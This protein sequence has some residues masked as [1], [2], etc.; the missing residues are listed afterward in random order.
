MF[1]LVSM[2]CAC[3]L[4]LSI[5]LGIAGFSPEILRCG[6][7]VNCQP[8]AVSIGTAT[9]WKLYVNCGYYEISGYT[10]A[11]SMTMCVSVL[12]DTQQTS[13]ARSYV[14]ISSESQPSVLVR[15]SEWW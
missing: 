12:Y 13:I 7:I 10:H 11:Q 6:K 2:F 9:K 15:K 8:L 3:D 5:S 14:A 1:L 4:T